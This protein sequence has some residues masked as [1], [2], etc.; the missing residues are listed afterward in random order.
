MSASPSLTFEGILKEFKKRLSAKE[1]EDF[2]E[3]KLE[4]VQKTILRI[5]NDQEHLKRSIN[6]TRLRSF[7][8]AMDQFGK[9]IE[10]FLNASPFVAAVWGPMKFMLMVNASPIAPLIWHHD[11]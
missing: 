2:K 5:Q 8:E 7:L 10:I 1:L 3:T 9:T 6:L 4:D 11:S